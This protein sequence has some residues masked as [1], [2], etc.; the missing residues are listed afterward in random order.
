MLTDTSP[1]SSLYSCNGS[2][3][4]FAFTFT[5]EVETDLEVILQTVATGAE[6]TLALTTGYT[7]SL[8]G[9]GTGSITTI[10]TYSSSYKIMVRAS[11]V[12][13]QTNDLSAGG[14]M[15]AAALETQLDNLVRMAQQLQEQANRSLKVTKTS[16]ST[17]LAVPDGS[18]DK[19]IGWDSAGTSLENKV[20]GISDDLGALT[21]SGGDALKVIRVNA[22]ETNIEVG[23]AAG[24]FNLVD[25]ETPQLF[26]DVA[27]DLNGG[28]FISSAGGTVVSAG[29]IKT[30]AGATSGTG[31]LYTQINSI[32]TSN[33]SS[34]T[35]GKI[36][37]WDSAGAATTVGPGT[38]GQVLTSQGAG[39]KPAFESFT[40]ITLDDPQAT[41]AGSSF[42]FTIPSGASKI[43][44]MLFGVSLSNT[45][46]LLIQ[47]GDG[48]GIETSGYAC[49]S[50]LGATEEAYDEGFGIKRGDSSTTQYGLVT[51]SL[52]NSSSFNWVASGG[53][54]AATNRTHVSGGKSLTAELTTV[55]LTRDGV[56]TFDAGEVNV[57]YE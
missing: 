18:A 7:V 32:S 27:L 14:T 31:T 15:S 23:E 45:D 33:F 54:S 24:T 38:D 22:G 53:L 19:I 41:T 28:S 40:P 51:L 9:D 50:S 30:L 42:D 21:I 3:T 26:A 5:V 11:T 4:S 35:G 13:T 17:G 25:D 6:A 10:S 47:I 20:N 1:K 16:S 46:D 8:S 39:E 52:E 2:T 57:S 12:K 49:I 44:V 55:R 43:N 56:N 37:T 34:G 29:D 36:I 48:G